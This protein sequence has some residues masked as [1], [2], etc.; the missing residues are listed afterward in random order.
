MSQN[1]LSALAINGGEKTITK[2][3]PPRGHFGQEEKDACNRVIDKAIAA[4]VAPGYGGVEEDSLCA[5]FAQMLGGGYAD[6][7]NG[8]TTAVYVALRAID[9]QPFTEVIVGPIT[10]PGGIMPITMMNCIPIIAD[11]K[12]NSF[13][14]SLDS[15]KERVTPW[16]S[17]IVVPHISGEPADIE[18][19]V[20]FAHSRGIK[21]VEDC[22]Q[23]HGATI[24][25]KMV[26]TF[27]DC[28]A[29]S[30]MFGKH[31]C[32]GGQGG[33]VFTKDY[34]TYLRARHASDRG[35]PFGV[36]GANGNVV[37]SLNY[38]M[39]EMH[40]AICRVQIQKMES[41]AARRNHYVNSIREKI[42]EVKALRFAP[43]PD[44][45]RPSYWFVCT[46]FDES[47][48]TCDKNTFIAALKAEGLNAVGAYVANPYTYQW[49]TRRK[50]FG[51]SGYPWAAPE[52]KGD[53]NKFYTMDDL[54]NCAESM[55]NILRLEASEAWDT[56][57]YIDLVSKAILKVWNAYKK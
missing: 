33:L 14:I 46:F 24:N 53:K 2:P 13:N 51:D 19:I 16:T 7:V 52:Y 22:A 34:N 40:A 50:V 8:G 55:K 12:P 26:G 49:Y 18:A 20:E 37:A 28:A 15:I 56:P 41:I 30:M 5:E 48:V 47:T 29:F 57:E 43:V 36:P 21:V 10:D 17:A 54:P 35:K 23:A 32:A 6:A 39:D 38:N 42:S 9:I 31:T 45:S 3:F 25:G 1:A 4:G 27:G 44:G 11:S